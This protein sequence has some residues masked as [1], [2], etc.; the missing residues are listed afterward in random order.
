MMIFLDLYIYKPFLLLCFSDNYKYLLIQRKSLSK[1]IS[2]K[3][4]WPNLLLLLVEF[5]LVTGD[6][7]LFYYTL[8]PPPIALILGLLFVP[9]YGAYF[10]IL[11]SYPSS[12]KALSS[13]RSISS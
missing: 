7:F 12:S 6:L 8:T 9:S 10:L 4:L 11:E 5:T 3:S 1:S 13:S 2:S